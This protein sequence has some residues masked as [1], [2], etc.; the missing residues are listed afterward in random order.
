MALESQSNA[1]LL[2]VALSPY[3]LL[4]YYNLNDKHMPRSLA[5]SPIR[6]VIK[7]LFMGIVINIV[8]I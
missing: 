4:V 2:L 1:L 5:T 7:F 3:L 6:E 8:I